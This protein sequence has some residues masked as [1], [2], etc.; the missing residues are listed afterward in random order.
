MASDQDTT[1]SEGLQRK[2]TTILSADVA[3]YSRLMAEDEEATLATFRGHRAVFETLVAHHHGRVFNTAGDAILAEFASA[4]E[5]VR[6]ATEIQAALRTRNDQLPPGRRVE[7]RLGVNLG[8]VMVQGTDLLG[9]GVNVAARLQAA[10]EPGGI[11]ISG[12]VYDQNSQ[13]AVAFVPAARRAELQEHSSAGADLFDHRRR[14]GGLAS[15]RSAL[16][17]RSLAVGC[18][19][20]ASDHRSRIFRLHAIPR[21]PP[22]RQPAGEEVY[23]GP[24]C[25][26][27]SPNDEARCFRAKGTLSGNRIA[28]RWPGRDPGVSVIL[29]G[30]V[31]PSGEAMIEMH[32][33]RSDGS[34]IFTLNMSGTLRGGELSTN[35]SFTG[36]RSALADVAAHG[37]LTRLR[38]ISRGLSPVIGRAFPACSHP[39]P[40]GARSRP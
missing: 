18:R 35:G 14:R 10:A 1:A 27:P 26:G 39:A 31:T 22:P 5:S 4:V 24:I 16:A 32:A 25:Y 37:W 15:F 19:V 7:F 13:Q 8:D 3:G 30:E 36:G 6:C 20:G 28:G 33:E 9:D 21:A 17:G 2:L 29:T 38:S 12:S 34:R 40:A 11:C 23:A